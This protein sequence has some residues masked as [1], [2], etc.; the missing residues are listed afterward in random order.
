MAHRTLVFGA[1][2]IPKRNIPR[3]LRDSLGQASGQEVSAPGKNYSH[4]SSA[5]AVHISRRLPYIAE[6]S[7]ICAIHSA[8]GCKFAP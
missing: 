5:F 4:H 8:S 7:A 1:A 3:C 2:N 6:F